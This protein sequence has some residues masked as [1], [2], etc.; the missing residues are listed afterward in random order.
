LIDAN[1]GRYTDLVYDFCRKS[2]HAGNLLPSHGKYVGAAG[3][4]LGITRHDERIRPKP[5][6]EAGLNW[7]IRRNRR[8]VIRHIVFDAN[9]WKSFIHD[10]LRVADG[11]QGC[12][13]LFGRPRITDHK[14]FADH[15]TAEHPERVESKTR[16]VDEWRL[17][18]GRENHFLDNLVGAAVAASVEGAS[19]MGTDAPVKRQRRQAVKLSEVQRR[20]GA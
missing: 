15:L 5:G 12:L 10:R 2:P 7:I 4:P 16:V 19:L 6:E 17:R 18:P 13:R 3:E 1:W 14:L 11:S 8:R 20:R 9:F